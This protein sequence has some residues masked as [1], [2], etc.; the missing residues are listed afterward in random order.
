MADLPECFQPQTLDEFVTS[1]N[2]IRIHHLTYPAATQVN[3]KTATKGAITKPKGASRRSAS[4]L[5]MTSIESR[6]VEL[7]Q[8]SSARLAE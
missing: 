8:P 2:N 1:Y 7:L 6:S 5:G 3:R 4:S